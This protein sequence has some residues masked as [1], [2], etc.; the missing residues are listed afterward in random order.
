MFQI[1][2]IIMIGIGAGTA[3]YFAVLKCRLS[4]VGRNETSLNEVAE[5]CKQNGSP[6][7]LVLSKDL[8]DAACCQSAV[9]ETLDYFKGNCLC[10]I[11]SKITRQ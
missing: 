7:V 1:I 4:L 2:L 5:I 3:K 6:E 10:F 11:S 9:Q 8:S